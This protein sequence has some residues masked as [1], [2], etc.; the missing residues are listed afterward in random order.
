MHIPSI[1][2]STDKQ[3]KLNNLSKQFSQASS[4][5]NYNKKFQNKIAS[6]SDISKHDNLENIWYNKPYTLTELNK[7]I[8]NKKGTATGL[9]KTS[10]T[11]LKHLPKKC[12]EIL[13]KLFNTIWS[14]GEIPKAWKESLIIPLHKQRKDPSKAESYRPVS[15]T[16][17]L[18]KSFEALINNRL[19]YYLE[20]TNNINKQQSGYR[21][22][23]STTDHL[24]RL[25]HYIRAAQHGNKYTVAVFLDF[26]KAFDM[27][28]KNGLLQK[29]YKKGIMVT[30]SILSKTFYPTELLELKQITCYQIITP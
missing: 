28:W 14:E 2:K 4:N 15:L 13:L 20:T 10:Y 26:T 7:A 8:N 30:C 25:Q 16:S 24:I 18:C 21:K 9:D 11:M 3:E 6:S 27:V 1:N 19:N 29:V 23:Y 22:T 12:K 17:N 5:Q